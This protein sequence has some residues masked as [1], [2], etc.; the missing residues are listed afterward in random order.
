MRV[1]TDEENR[2]CQLMQ[3]RRV[4]G[5]MSTWKVKSGALKVKDGSVPL[6]VHLSGVP[7]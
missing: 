1:Q 3:L 5:C 7:L 2:A 4:A 6:G